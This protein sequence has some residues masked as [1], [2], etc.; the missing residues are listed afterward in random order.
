MHREPSYFQI[1]ASPSQGNYFTSS[2]AFHPVKLCIPGE[3][4]RSL[5]MV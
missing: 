1:G 5:S 2:P 4:A 3:R